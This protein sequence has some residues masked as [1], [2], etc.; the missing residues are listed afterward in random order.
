MS[1]SVSR[2]HEVIALN[3]GTAQA[4]GDAY[5]GSVENANGSVPLI[6]AKGLLAP[7]GSRHFKD[8]RCP[9]C[10]HFACRGC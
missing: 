6:E 7:Y 4:I 9:I 1:Q 5:P 3:S 8:Q 2:L 10:G